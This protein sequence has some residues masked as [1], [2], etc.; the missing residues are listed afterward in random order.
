MYKQIYVVYAQVWHAK[1]A[2]YISLDRFR[3]K[4]ALQANKEKVVRISKM[5]QE[6]PT[7]NVAIIST[8]Y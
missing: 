4:A 2:Q 5:S 1:W 6:F 3:M 8:Y 7:N